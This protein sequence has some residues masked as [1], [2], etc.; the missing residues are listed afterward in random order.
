MRREEDRK[1]E[2]SSSP[3]SWTLTLLFEFNIWFFLKNL[4]LTN[5]LLLSLEEIGGKIL[6]ILAYLPLA[7]LRVC[8]SEFVSV[9]YWIEKRYIV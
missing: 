9:F 3:L 5:I 8:S 2:N 1:I 7:E 4:D 6:E